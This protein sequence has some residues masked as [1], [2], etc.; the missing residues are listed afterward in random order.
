MVLSVIIVDFLLVMPILQ[1]VPFLFRKGV[2]NSL[3]RNI[4]LPDQ[5]FCEIIHI[6]TRRQPTIPSYVTVCDLNR[7][8]DHSNTLVCT[9]FHIIC[10]S[11]LP[12]RVVRCPSTQSKF[13][14]EY[15]WRHVAMNC[16][17]NLYFCTCT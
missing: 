5:S 9:Y 11:G 17:V 1:N 12:R 8:T 13:A 16:F 14:S 4:H 6:F 3:I 10:C 2:L 15:L 7:R